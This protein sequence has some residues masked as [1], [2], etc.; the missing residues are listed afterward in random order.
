VR[1]RTARAA[2]RRW[3]ARNAEMEAHPFCPCGR[4]GVARIYSSGVVGSVQPFWW[5]CKV[6]ADVPLEASWHRGAD[7]YFDTL[8]G[9]ARE[10][11]KSWTW[12][13]ATGIISYCDCGTHVGEKVDGK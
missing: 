2:E 1:S 10:D 9:C 3:A 6:H 11:C 7:G 13:N 4:E 8:H 5:R 12:S